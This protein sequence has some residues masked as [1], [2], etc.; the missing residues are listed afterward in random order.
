MGK[1]WRAGF[2]KM[3]ENKKVVLSEASKCKNNYA[4]KVAQ[5]RAKNPSKTHM[6][7]FYS[8]QRRGSSTSRKIERENRLDL[9]SG[10]IKERVLLKFRFNQAETKEKEGENCK[11]KRKSEMVGGKVE[12]IQ[13]IEG[14]LQRET[15]RESP[16][17]DSESPLLFRKRKN[18]SRR[19]LGK[20]TPQ[21]DTE[22]SSPIS[23]KLSKANHS[24]TKLMRISSSTSELT[25]QNNKKNNNIGNPLTFSELEESKKKKKH[26][27][28]LSNRESKDSLLRN[29]QLCLGRLYKKGKNLIEESKGEKVIDQNGKGH[30]VLPCRVINREI[31][32]E[33]SG[34]PALTKREKNLLFFDLDKRELPKRQR[35]RVLKKSLLGSQLNST[36]PFTER[37]LEKST[38]VKMK[39]E[40]RLTD[41]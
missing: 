41:F 1:S 18:L 20:N 8:I 37:N 28:Q 29:P 13:K 16:Q 22:D 10:E 9:E 32:Q 19:L 14:E 5:E 34:M 6:E 25:L 15:E 4:V 23:M 11:S 24:L 7:Y 39:R 26:Q 40:E 27:S 17:K 2:E 35:F 38:D 12:N 36:V 30:G 31:S 33:A 3:T 21:N